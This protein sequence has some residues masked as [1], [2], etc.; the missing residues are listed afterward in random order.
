M[1]LRD[2]FYLFRHGGFKSYIKNIL[3]VIF[4]PQSLEIT[5]R[6]TKEKNKEETTIERY[7][8]GQVTLF[9]KQFNYVDLPSFDFIKNEIFNLEIYKFNSVKKQPYII[10]CGANIGLSVLYFKK[11]YPEARITAFEPDPNV[12]RV[13]RTNVKTYELTTIELYEK[14]LWD[15]E[16]EMSFFS[17]GADGGRIEEPFNEDKR[18]IKLKTVRLSK[19]INEEVDFL[20]ID[21]EGAEYK[22]LN[23]CKDKLHLVKNLFV[24]YHSLINEKQNLSELL[25]VLSDTGFRYYVSSIGI[26]SPHPFVKKNVTLGMDNQLNI[27]ATR[28]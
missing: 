5:I 8:H 21:I 2:K 4:K 18:I 17:E 7:V 10:D 20:K 26:K 1:T 3:Y 9:G 25:K 6:T 27:F 22:V 16:G 23:E 19:F 13:L 14:A 28:N 12:Y 11:V 24:E 15:E